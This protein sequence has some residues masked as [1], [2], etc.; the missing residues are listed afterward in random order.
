[1][2]HRGALA[3]I[4]AAGVRGPQQ[5]LALATLKRSIASTAA[6]Q[7]ARSNRALELKYKD[8]S[9]TLAVPLPLSGFDEERVFSIP[10]ESTV[11]AIKAQIEAED[12]SVQ[13]VDIRSKRGKSFSPED[14]LN[15]ILKDDFE[16]LINDRVLPVTAPVFSGNAY[17]S[18]LDEGDLDVRSVAQKSAIISLRY[19]LE[20]LGKW[21]IS[22]AEFVL[23]CKE[24]GIPKKQASEILNAFHQSGV[25]FS[26]RNSDDEDLQHSIFLQPRSVIDSYL[27]SIGLSPV[28][29]QLFVQ[30]RENLLQKIQSLEPEHVALV[31]LRKELHAAATRHANVIA[32]GLSTSLVGTFGLYFWLSF[33]H[34]SWDIMEPVTYFTGFGMSVVGYTWWSLTNQEYE[35]ENIY[36]YFYKKK[37]GKLVA[38]AK[39]DQARLDAVT[40]ALD[41]KK[42]QL[43]EVEQVLTRPTHLQ[44]SYL[45]LLEESEH[46]WDRRV[47]TQAATTS[48][49]AAPSTSNKK[50]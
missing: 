30:E 38:N 20:T 21:K 42:H 2:L 17:V 10:P 22:Y 46:S 44:S 15:N 25:V 1:M 19:A 11:A 41:Q 27:E 40:Q 14:T 34:F 4:A 36:D 3:L 13:T 32:A 50:L 6:L 5:Q 7:Y 37:L 43:A 9:C 28:T 23:M 33:I 24:Y 18:L 12:K 29:K 31:N 39:F 8:G 16:L 48:A 35:Y 45:H 26:F 47:L 49:A